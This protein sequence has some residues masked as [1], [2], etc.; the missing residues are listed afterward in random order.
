M[1]ERVGARTGGGLDRRPIGAEGL[2]LGALGG[3]GHGATWVLRSWGSAARTGEARQRVRAR[4][5]E[6]SGRQIGGSTDSPRPSRGRR[7]EGMGDDGTRDTASTRARTN[8]SAGRLFAGGLRDATH[9]THS[10][11]AG[12]FFFRTHLASAFVYRNN[13]NA[14]NTD[15][16]R[17]AE[18]RARACGAGSA[19]V[20][21]VCACAIDALAGVGVRCGR[22]V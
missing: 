20:E 10:S 7:A 16:R 1:L 2:G 22:A 6:L 9:A 5:N 3:I 12:C 17:C 15:S 19:R 11:G 8:A 18:T 21:R 13:T 14:V 4:R